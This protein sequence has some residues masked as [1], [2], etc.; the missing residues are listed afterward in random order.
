MHIGFFRRVLHDIRIY[1]RV[2]YEEK[3]LKYISYRYRF[4]YRNILLESVG[5]IYTRTLVS[6]ITS[7]VWLSDY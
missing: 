6:D 2:T 1:V 5:P 7:T 4:H 3:Q